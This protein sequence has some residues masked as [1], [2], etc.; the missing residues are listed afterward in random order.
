MQ[1][2]YGDKNPLRMLDGIL[3]SLQFTHTT[4]A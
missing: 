1:Y 4:K 3:D 2:Y